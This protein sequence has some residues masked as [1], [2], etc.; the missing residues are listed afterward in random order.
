[1]KSLSSLVPLILAAAF[2]GSSAATG[3]QARKLEPLVIQE[4]GSFAV[5]GGVAIEPGT[6]DPLQPLNPAG[7]TY[8]GDHLYAFYQVPVNARRLPLVMWLTSSSGFR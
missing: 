2:P 7:Q 4:Q 1:M 6:F 3:Q 8:H 5:G